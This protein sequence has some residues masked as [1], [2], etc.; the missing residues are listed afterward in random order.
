MV[1]SIG[2]SSDVR[3]GLAGVTIAAKGTLALARVV[4]RSFAEHHPGVP[5]FVL[6]A[7]EV[8]GFFDPAQEPYELL[9]LR[10]V[11]I[12]ERERF[13][14][15]LRRE[16]L[17]YAATPYAISKLLALGY[18]RVLFIK[19][20]SFVLGE[21]RTVASSLPA[22][23]IGL[24]PHLLEPL[25]GADGEDRELTILLSGVFNA[26]LVAVAGDGTSSDL[27]SWWQD[28]VHRH[29]RHA[30]AEGM[31]Y[32]QRWLDLASAY[33]PNITVLHDAGLNVGH[34]NLP[35]RR[36]T[37]ADGKVLAEG[38][39][40]RLFR[41]SG[42]DP[43]HPE[44]ATR[45]HARLQTAELGDAAIVFKRYHQTLFEEGWAETKTW[46][47]A[48]GS[49]SNGVPIPGVARDIYLRLEDAERFGNPFDASA[50]YFAWLREP[51]KRGG[52]NRLW[53]G[54][55]EGRPDLQAA[56]PDVLGR[57]RRSFLRWTRSYGV[58]EHTVPEALQ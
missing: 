26:G 58:V 52:P 49:F 57:H 45:Y 3:Q 35:D 10:D 17:S 36:V 56:F 34:W 30:V 4:A 50:G 25:G 18:Q 53:L 41:F 44:V 16:P 21:L 48:Y 27:L 31:H 15:G 42:Y 19:Q 22:G 47:F 20:E 2:A 1:S 8:D 12:P 13:T 6:L 7:D 5:F 51:V 38:R 9:L 23:G 43:D 46:P 29:C 33:F 55:Y 39:P 37:L 54:V 28:R 11:E 32:E 14:F 24:T 40:C